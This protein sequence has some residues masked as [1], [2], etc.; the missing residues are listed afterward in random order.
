[1]S[2]EDP[3]STALDLVL[4]HDYS[5]FPIYS[6]GRYAG[7]LTTNAVVRWLADQLRAS[8]GLAESESIA[9]AVAFAEPH[10]VARLVPRSTT[11]TDALHLL[12]SGG[13][14]GRSVPA[15][16]ITHSGTPSERPLRLVVADD[17]PKLAGAPR[18]PVEV[19]PV[20]PATSGSRRRMRVGLSGKL[21][22]SLVVLV[23]TALHGKG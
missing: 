13:S 3:I 4:E 23:V 19:P 7:L 8:G 2:P 1:M 5:Q 18:V 22:I 9:Q 20:G 11:V 14:G 10:E 17:L 16:I 12:A 15:L 21:R 6:A